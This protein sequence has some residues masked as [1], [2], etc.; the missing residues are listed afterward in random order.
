MGCIFRYCIEDTPQPCWQYSSRSSLYSYPCQF[1]SW[2][3][4]LGQFWGGFLFL[5]NCLQGLLAL[6]PLRPL[7]RPRVP[8]RPAQ[9]RRRGREF[10]G[11]SELV[12]KKDRSLLE[13]WRFRF[14]KNHDFLFLGF[15]QQ[16]IWN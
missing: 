11:T 13:L 16:F 6:R 2:A 8:P 9:S 15:I 5:L 4:L 12:G 3:I 7:S 14:I 1:D 10:G